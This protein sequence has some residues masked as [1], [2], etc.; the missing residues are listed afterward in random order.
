MNPIPH[1]RIRDAYD[2]VLAH[3]TPVPVY[4]TEHLR[5]AV[6]PKLD[7]LHISATEVGRYS[8]SIPLDDFADDLQ[9]EA[10]SQIARAHDRVL[11]HIRA[12]V[13]TI[14][15]LT[16]RTGLPTYTVKNS[17]DMLTRAGLCQRDGTAIDTDSGRR[18]NRYSATTEARHD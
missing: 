10:R 11:R 13:T 5:V 6:D 3:T 12:G 8:A 7:N 15:Q 1:D 17:L 14:P 18:T 16:R 9:T 2:K 4:L